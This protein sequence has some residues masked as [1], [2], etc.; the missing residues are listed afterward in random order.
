[1]K[2][3][4]PVTEASEEAQTQTSITD[5]ILEVAAPVTA[6]AAAA[7]A[8]VVGFMSSGSDQHDGGKL[9]R[10]TSPIPGTFP[11]TPVVEKSEAATGMIDEVKKTDDEPVPE[12]KAFGTGAEATSAGGFAAA[13]AADAKANTPPT[14]IPSSSRM[15]SAPETKKG[16]TFTILPVPSETAPEGTQPLADSTYRDTSKSADVGSLAPEPVPQKTASSLP[17]KTDSEATTVFEPVNAESNLVSSATTTTQDKTSELKAAALASSQHAAET[18]AKALSPDLPTPPTLNAQTTLSGLTP[19]AGVTAIGTAT[20]NESD[21]TGLSRLVAT[22]S[23]GGEH[24]DVQADAKAAHVEPAIVLDDTKMGKPTVETLGK[25]GDAAVASTPVT[26]SVPTDD[27]VQEVHALGTAIVT[28]GGKESGAL[29]QEI[30]ENGKSSL[31]EGALAHLNKEKEGEEGKPPAAPEKSGKVQEKGPATPAKDT[32]TK[33]P[34]SQASASK[35][36][37]RVSGVP[38]EAGTTDSGKK[39]KKGGFLR[40]LKKAFS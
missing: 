11:D 20:D 27:G 33:T 13:L 4:A 39:K 8:A 22:K 25:S 5:K 16:D 17:P 34:V 37:K 10:E 32:P 3:S 12:T 2:E 7:G 18:A 1:M 38:S 14:H 15:E 29:K 35:D 30:L 36:A 23:P 26:V 40:K 6:A 9:D 19:G 21:E 31:P 28:D 24:V